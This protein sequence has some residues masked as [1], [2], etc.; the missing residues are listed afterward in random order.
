MPQ[1]KFSSND[2]FADKFDDIKTAGMA[3]VGVKWVNINDDSVVVTYADDFD[4][5][6]FIDAIKSVGVDLSE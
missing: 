4:K 1:I 6:A 3:V 5:P 2:T